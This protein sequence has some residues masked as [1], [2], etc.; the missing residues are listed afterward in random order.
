MTL[1]GTGIGLR[2][3]HLGPLAEA[4][5]ET[6]DFLEAAPENWIGI[7]GR[8]ARQF[9]TATAGR[10]L[11]CHGLSLSIG[12]PA[13]LDEDLVGAIG[14]FMDHHDAVLYSEHLSYTGDDGHLYDL[15]PIPFTAESVE[16]VAARVRRVQA[17]LG[18]RMA[19]ENVSYYAAPGPE[20]S[21]AEFLLG[22]LEQADCE[23]LLD[24]NNVYVNSVNQDY[25]ARAFIDALPAERVRYFHV[26]GHHREAEDLLVDTHGAPVADPVWALL[27][28]S[29]RRFGPVP[30]LLERDFDIP[31]LEQ[32]VDEAREVTRVRHDAVGR[33][34][35]ET[36][37][38]G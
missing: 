5:P 15:L 6:I 30:T 33:P 28:Y 17:I 3:A 25:D 34:V 27:D 19:L 13:P 1:Q 31:P 8:Q 14:R 32:L 22:V 35:A 12:G 36:A 7:G 9:R 4:V 11:V 26:A 21:E 38:H 37:A 29:Y 20:M 18:R 10:P 24:V 2:R 23:L 16:H